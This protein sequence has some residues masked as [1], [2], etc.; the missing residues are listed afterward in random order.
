MQIVAYCFS[1]LIASIITA[2]GSFLIWK[3][4]LEDHVKSTKF[5]MYMVL[6]KMQYDID[7]AYN[8]KINN[9]R[10]MISPL[11]IYD[12]TFDYI[13]KL[14]ALRKYLTEE[15]INVINQ[16][17]EDIKSFDNV[18]MSVNILLGKLNEN[19]LGNPA[20]KMVDQ[21]NYDSLMEKYKKDLENFKVNNYYNGKLTLIM[22][23]LKK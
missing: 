23:K 13:Q 5:Q 11:W 9:D 16:F 17:F 1:G 8:R 14:C 4:K 3:I 19:P 20:F 6:R 12:G 2:L 21:M 15:E 22:D 7:A 10:Y 18:R